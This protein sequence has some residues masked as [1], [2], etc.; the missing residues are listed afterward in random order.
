MSSTTD[1]RSQ[2]RRL[3]AQDLAERLLPD[4]NMN[5]FVAWAPDLFAFTSYILSHTGAYQLVVS[6]PSNELWPPPNRVLKEWLGVRFEPGD[7]AEKGKW[8]SRSENGLRERLSHWLGAFLTF[9]A[10]KGTK[11]WELDT[12]DWH[13]SRMSAD[14]GYFG[15]QWLRDLDR[16]DKDQPHVNT[17]IN[18]IA[19]HI[20]GYALASITA[21]VTGETGEFLTEFKQQ[22]L[23]KEAARLETLGVRTEEVELQLEEFKK[24]LEKQTTIS[25]GDLL[26][27]DD[28]SNWK[29]FVQII[30]E[31]W[32]ET[33]KLMKDEEFQLINHALA[34]EEGN[35]FSE[36]DLAPGF[37]GTALPYEEYAAKFIGTRAN[38]EPE[39]SREKRLLGILLKNAPPLLLACW[40]YFYDEVTREDFYSGEP[41]RTLDVSDL[42]C[43]RDD[44]Q[45]NS[46]HK[47]Q[48]WKLSQSIFTLH[49]IADLCCTTWGIYPVDEPNKIKG[50]WYA[51]TLLYD[52]G[53]LSTVNAERGRVIPKRHNPG[54]GITL[55]SISSNLAFHR[56]SV[57][58]V[59]RKT[60]HTSLEDKL[61]EKEAEEK[62]SKKHVN[63]T[64][65]VLLMPFP[66]DVKAKDFHEDKRAEDRVNMSGEYGF[67]IYNP[68]ADISPDAYLQENADLIERVTNLIEDAKQELDNDRFVDIVVFPESSLSKEQFTDLET[69]LAK[70]SE[71]YDEAP[72][73]RA[74][75]DAEIDRLN[76]KLINAA[77]ESR[78]EYA[79][80]A[81]KI[82]DF[83]E[84]LARQA[85][86]TIKS[87]SILIAG[88]RESR[89]DILKDIREKNAKEIEKEKDQDK[90][91]K[92][93]SDE[94]HLSESDINFD[95]NAVYCKYYNEIDKNYSGKPDRLTRKFKQYK[96]HRWQ[97]NASQ[98][99]S[100]GLS[101]ILETE[102]HKIW[103]E[104]MKVPKR[105]VSFLNVG[106]ALT[107]SHLVCEDLARQDPIADLIR[108]VGP[109]LVVTLLMDGPQLKNR[110]SSRY[111][112]ILADDPGSSVITLT[113]F[114]MTKRYNS[115][116][117][118]MSRVIGLWSES[119]GTQ[120]REIELA[121]GAEAV[122]LTLRL[123]P[124]KERTADG[125]EE[126]I[127]TNT[128]SLVD[129]IQVYPR[130]VDRK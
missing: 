86:E 21:P 34:G 129:V 122:L 71:E 36:D 109:S 3:K 100:Y 63:K 99:K 106:K 52:K 42:L 94:Q 28:V 91:A 19:D 50:K 20:E 116:Y 18:A 40:A 66:L 60:A 64:V 14:T 58:V 49:A 67:F 62:Q 16:F 80:Y 24:S 83:Q 57:D 98:I 90:L 33:L 88:V 113:S 46:A 23:A 76:K 119:K 61:S 95:R 30:G 12:T 44:I 59:W 117:G 13:S 81:E 6:P 130:P 115:P 120:V 47:T 104:A 84:L 7:G 101:Q 39:K 78:D 73:R 53:S 9:K 37:D 56:S 108:H 69:R 97:L 125:R 65:S 92:L 70:K 48:L 11:Q 26:I 17:K 118:L 79:E 107:I 1:Y 41:G 5:E 96:H 128:L 77:V 103:W 85:R 22:A 102:N 25:L 10:E 51:E 110:W 114:G 105:R 4:L 35:I 87:P 72:A 54:V 43:N 27:D 124:H 31:E 8:V 74:E 112:S 121:N 29:H 89:A 38:E 123:E 45:T 2:G 75:A 127:P 55:R 32:N 68:Q 15:S 111:A 93:R 126:R 82:S